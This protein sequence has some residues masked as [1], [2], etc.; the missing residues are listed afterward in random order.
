METKNCSRC[1][2]K[3][4]TE[5]FNWRNKA[6]GTKAVAC[7]TCTRLQTKRHHAN[8]RDYY[9][10]K[11][12]RFSDTRRKQVHSLLLEY[13]EEHHCVDCEESDPRC[14]TFDHV[15]GKK[16]MNISTMIKDHSWESIQKEIKK[17][18]VRCSNCHMK[19]TADDFGWFTSKAP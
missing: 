8:N 2:K 16:N 12:R 17:C 19:K 18:D 4:A 11:A 1:G 13:F 15:R 10:N 9:S 3:K 7:K 5:E 14:L 6:K